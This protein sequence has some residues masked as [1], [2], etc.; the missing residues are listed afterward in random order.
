MEIESSFGRNVVATSQRLELPGTKRIRMDLNMRLSREHT[1]S[2]SSELL[3]DAPLDDKTCWLNNTP[4]WS[5]EHPF[6]YDLTI[7]LS[8]GL[9]H[10]IDEVRTNVGMRSISWNNG[11]GTL[12]LNNQPYFHAL[13]LD[14]GYWPQTLMTPPSQTALKADIEMS[15]AMGFNGCRKHQKVEDPVFMYWADKLGYMV[16]GEMASCYQF[17]KEMV[18]RFDQEWMEMVRRDINHPSI[19]CWTPANESWGY[20][21]LG[22]S[23]EERNHLR[24]LYYQTKTLDPTRPINDNCGWEHVRTDLSTFHD[25]ADASALTERCSSITDVLGRGRSVFLHPIPDRDEGS[26]HKPGAPVLCTEF[27][28]VNIKMGGK[29]TEHAKGW[30]YTS[31]S[32][33]DDLLKRIEKLCMAIVHRGHCCG[34]VYTQ[35]T[36]I[37]QETNGLYTYDRR[38][39]LPAAKVKEVMQLIAATYLSFVP[40]GSSN[41]GIYRAAFSA[42]TRNARLEQ[43]QYLIAECDI[44]GQRQNWTSSRIDLNDCLHNEWGRLQ[45]AR[46]GNFKA[47]ARQIRLEDNG[48]AVSC[49][50]GDGRGHWVYN[51]ARFDERIRNENGRLMLM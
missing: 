49:E 3:H 30:G 38:E 50:L 45:W 8:D 5:P 12:R 11:D 35:L 24:S 2:L 4:L 47:S 31:A 10:M 20:G 40:Q 26:A 21:S 48:C 46:G 39:K 6:L 23:A 32:D 34:F 22:T 37:E 13:V 15:K 14:Q 9:G 41:Q 36:D 51:I 1:E 25:Y 42:S 33:P 18:D 19:V 27:G 29:D 16:W 17:S 43:S 7:R 28:G 44:D